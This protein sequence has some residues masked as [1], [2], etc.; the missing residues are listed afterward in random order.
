MKA[1]EAV[2]VGLVLTLPAVALVAVVL[3]AMRPTMRVPVALLWVFN[4]AA[5]G[6]AIVL[7]RILNDP[8]ETTPLPVRCDPDP[9]LPY[10]SDWMLLFYVVPAWVVGNV[11][12]GFSVLATGKSPTRHLG[13]S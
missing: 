7:R 4:V 13:S 3:H 2:L 6:W 8:C 9:L 1:D 12:L 11:V 10:W 5:L